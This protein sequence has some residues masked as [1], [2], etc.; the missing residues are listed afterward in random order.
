[1]QF[2]DL[3]AQYQKY[4]TEIDAEIHEVLDSSQYIMGGKISEFENNLSSYTN[5]KHSIGCSSGTDALLIALMALDLDIGD[6]VITT[7]FTFIATAEVI[8]LLKLRP[9]FV[10]IED[11]TY[12]IDPNKIEEKISDKTKVIMPVGIFGQP[13]DMDAI[14]KIA[15]KHN[16]TVIEDAAQSFGSEYK[17]KKSGNLSTIGC[18]SFFPAKVLGGYGDGGAIFTSDDALALKMRQ[19]LNHG[20]TERYVHKYIGI[21]ARLDALQAAIINVKLK[22]FDEEIKER[23]AVAE[24]YN[25]AFKNNQ[26]MITPMV[27]EDRTSVYAQYS[28]RVKDGKRQELINFLSSKGVPT[29]IHYP[30]PLHLQEVFAYLNQGKGSFPIAEQIS[31]EIMSLPMSAFLTESDQKQVIELVNYD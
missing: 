1:M 4:K 21:N 8:A 12:N 29:A 27:K 11:E 22:Y 3:Q 14:N 10:D 24:R 31:N 26:T 9:V 18:T 23:N 13:A 25:E 2:V 17:N 20:Q 5:A 28:I 19:L 30:I 7:P 16:L 6:E 15:S